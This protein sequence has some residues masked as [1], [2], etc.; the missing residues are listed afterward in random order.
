MREVG[1][2]SVPKRLTVWVIA[3]FILSICSIAMLWVLCE[4]SAGRPAC[5]PSSARIV[6]T[7]APGNAASEVRGNNLGSLARI[8]AINESLKQR[9]KGY[10]RTLEENSS[11]SRL[12]LPWLQ[13]FSCRFLG[14]GNEKVYLGREGWLFYRP[15]VDHLLGKGFLRDPLSSKER[16]VDPLPALIRFK[17]D[18]AARGIRLLV[19]PVPSKT[20]M[21]PSYLSRRF[22]SA[23]GPLENPSYPIFLEQLRFHGIEVLDLSV[24]LSRMGADSGSPCYLKTDTHWTPAGMEQA[25]T[26]IAGKIQGTEGSLSDD[27]SPFHRSASL[28]V[29][30]SG[31]LAVMLK[32]PPEIALYPRETTVI[33]PVTGP[34]GNPWRPVSSSEVLVLGDSFARIYS[35]DD[36]RWGTSAG[37]AEQ[38]S[39]FLQRPVDLVAINAGGASTSRQALARSPERLKGVKT[40]VYEF[41]MRELSSGDWRVI[42]LPPTTEK[43]PAKDPAL[44]RISGTI[45]GITLPPSPGSTPY[46]DVI[47]CLHLRDVSGTSEKE[48]L[49][50]VYGL[51]NNL[52]TGA[53]TLQTGQTIS[54]QVV[55]WDTK[56]NELGSIQRREP[57][58]QEADLEG[59]YWSDNYSTSE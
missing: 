53:A 54:L 33:H 16:S 35:G 51:K 13:A 20:A 15:D 7:G 26:L 40:V 19:V 49:V 39:Y 56:E 24:P 47:T 59:V 43:K 5:K 41:A 30:N 4:A 44:R 9:L 29:T 42:P 2:T 25:A 17:E 36:L 23:D 14:Q 11:L 34:D 55:P 48:I 10:E 32:L 38:L 21:A 1:V 12:T 8:T 57:S 31:D 58:G 45:E 52:L 50:F 18:L 46:R 3:F 22:A 27:T 28:T 37:L 6:V